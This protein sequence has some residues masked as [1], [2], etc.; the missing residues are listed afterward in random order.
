MRLK[1]ASETQTV[2]VRFSRKNDVFRLV[3]QFLQ[4]IVTPRPSPDL[5]PGEGL[6][7]FRTVESSS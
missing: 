5:V 4:S 7:V 1:L 2:L 6:F 3:R